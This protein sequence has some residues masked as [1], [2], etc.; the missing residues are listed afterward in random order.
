MV[1][2]RIQYGRGCTA[3]RYVYANEWLGWLVIERLEIEGRGSR[4]N[5][6]VSTDCL[7]LELASWEWQ[8]M[9][10]KMDPLVYPLNTEN[11]KI[12]CY[13]NNNTFWLFH[14]VLFYNRYSSNTYYRIFLVLGVFYLAHT[15]Y[16]I[17]MWPSVTIWK[18]NLMCRYLCLKS[19]TESC[20]NNVF[21][22]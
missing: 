18:Y 13:H 9:E 15:L 14:L 22:M 2:A 17:A 19:S 21:L 11:P 3:D 4:I 20:I 8:L 5:I 7:A 16:C 10:D 1:K 6:L 12:V